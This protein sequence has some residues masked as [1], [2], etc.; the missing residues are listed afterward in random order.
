MYFIK[1]IVCVC[2]HMWWPKEDIRHPG[3][4][5]TGSWESL[6][7]NAGTKYGHLQEQCVLRGISPALGEDGE[8]QTIKGRCVSLSN[9]LEGSCFPSPW[10]T[11]AILTV[12]VIQNWGEKNSQAF[13]KQYLLSSSTRVAKGHKID[14]HCMNESTA[15]WI[16]SQ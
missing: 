15:L 9:R 10:E 1:K 2:V 4:G 3:V 12:I 6:N 13:K 8:N 14:V 7:M 5:I 11:N 16:R